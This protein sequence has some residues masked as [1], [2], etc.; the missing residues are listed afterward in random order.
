M[1]VNGFLEM[2]S[3]IMGIKKEIVFENFEINGH[4]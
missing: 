3:E 2:L 1:K 4:M